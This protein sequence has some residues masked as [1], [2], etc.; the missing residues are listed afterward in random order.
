[1]ARGRSGISILMAGRSYAS[2]LS[3]GLPAHVTLSLRGHRVTGEGTCTSPSNRIIAVCLDLAILV[4]CWEPFCAEQPGDYRP[5]TRRLDQRAAEARGAC[6]VEEWTRATCAMARGR[7]VACD[8]TGPYRRVPSERSS[9]RVHLLRPTRP[10]R[11]HHHPHLHQ[12]ER[13]IHHCAL[14]REAA[15]SEFNERLHRD[16]YTDLAALQRSSSNDGTAG[17]R[18]DGV[19]RLRR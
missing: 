8:G 10:E 12:W 17:P 13:K 14:C 3:L 15:N 5:C 6:I 18:I 2:R 11:D 16:G 7:T 9:R 19:Y 1:M 4:R